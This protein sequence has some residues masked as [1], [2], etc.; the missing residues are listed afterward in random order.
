MKNLPAILVITLITFYI[1]FSCERIE[2]YPDEPVIEF[3]SFLLKDTIDE[4]D[5]QI[6]LGKLIFSFTDG[7]GDIG[8]SAGDT[9]PPYCDT[10]D[11][12]YNLFI[13]LF[14]KTDSE[15]Y[16]ADLQIPLYYR[17]PY[18]V[19]DG[20]NKTLKGQI[21]INFEYN[22]ILYDTIKYEFYMVDRALHQ[23]N[24]ETTPEIIL[25]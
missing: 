13:S 14:E 2:E 4:L 6:K 25:Q 1:I 8:L 7:D 22:S 19:Q 21:H 16:E 5:N 12:H 20:Q 18:A 17:I 15:F 24:I 9:L 3:Q 10:C 11:Y 23:S